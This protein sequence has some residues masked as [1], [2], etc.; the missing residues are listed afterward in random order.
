MAHTNPSRHPRW[1]PA[2]AILL[3]GAAALTWVWWPGD[4]R[5]GQDRV[6]LTVQLVLG[7][8]AFLTLWLMFFRV[9]HVG[10]AGE[11]SSLSLRSWP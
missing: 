7:V 10:H 3:A 11:P 2:I 6:Y 5:S 1:W 9:F 4:D 8:L